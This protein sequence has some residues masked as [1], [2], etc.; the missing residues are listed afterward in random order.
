MNH[1]KNRNSCTSATDG[2]PTGR[3]VGRLWDSAPGEFTWQT[4]F[5]F[6]SF[7]LSLSQDQLALRGSACFTSNKWRFKDRIFPHRSVYHVINDWV[8]L[9]IG[10]QISVHF[11]PVVSGALVLFKFIVEIY[12]LPSFFSLDALFI[13]FLFPGNMTLWWLLQYLDHVLS[14]YSWGLCDQGF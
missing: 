12:C 7:L 2:A 3:H 1:T 9:F 11:P 14:Q 10:V 4:P 8:M 5:I 13:H 6:L